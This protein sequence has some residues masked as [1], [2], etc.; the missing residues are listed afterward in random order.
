MGLDPE[1]ASVERAGKQ[2]S[3]APRHPRK[4]VHV[5]TQKDKFQDKFKGE[6]NRS[7]ERAVGL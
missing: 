2:N 4:R 3:P 5:R 7:L 1:F 6:V